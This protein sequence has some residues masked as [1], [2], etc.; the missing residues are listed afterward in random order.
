LTIDYVKFGTGGVKVSPMALGLGFRGQFDRN[1]AVRVIH[2]ALDSGINL[3]DCANV[4]GWMD[5]RKNIGSSE[6]ALGQALKGRRDDVVITSK[7]F[8]PIGSGPNDRGA[9]RYHIMREIE[10]SLNRIDTDHIDVYIFH[11]VEDM[12]LFE[13]QFRTMETLIQ[14]GKIRYVGVSN[15]QAWQIIKALEVQKQINAQP[16]IAVQNPYSLMNR[17]QEDELFPMVRETGVGI[18]AYSPLGVG[19]LSGT[20]K[21]S[22]I[23]D[24]STLWG[25]RRKGQI[26]R[27]MQGRAGKVIAAVEEVASDLGVSMP[28][29]AMAWVMSHP[30]ITVAISGADTVDQITDVAGAL[31]IDLPKDM[32]ARL[33]DVSY[34]MRA[35]LDGTPTDVQ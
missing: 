28:Q 10:R 20:Y 4:Y 35:L 21:S 23:P 30:E 16:L 1:E 24:E 25:S 17:A 5:D 3:I 2:T 15:F 31:E 27:Y 13:E 33:D 34:G 11:G 19:L 12:T 22:E 14:Q 18:M 7:V 9:S 8:S 26:G 32:I 29:V 6:Q